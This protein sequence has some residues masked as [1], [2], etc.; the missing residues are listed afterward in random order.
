MNSMVFGQYVNVDSWVH[1]LDPRTKILSLFTLM[2]CLFLINNI[3]ILIGFFIFELIIVLSTRIPINKFLNSFK[4]VAMLLIFTFI[5]QIL[6]NTS[7]DILSINGLLLTHDFTLSIISLMIGIVLLILYLY[8][9]KIIKKFRIVLFVIILILI[10]YVQTINFNDYIIV[11]YTISIHENAF[12]SGIKVLLRVINLLTLS[13]LLTFCTKPTDLNSGI[14]GVLKPF[15]FMKSQISILAMMISIALRSIPTL[16]N[17]SKKIL[18]A[19]ASRGVDFEEGSLKDKINQIISLLVPMFVISYKKAEDLA[20]AMEARGYIPGEDRTKL[21]V[22]K[23]HISD[24]LVYLFV[25]LV[26]VGIIFGKIYK[27]L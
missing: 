4:A 14:E 16:L 23:Y 9:G 20:Y 25:C 19:Q 24:V 11:N 27:V 6:F 8:S 26:I 21:Q 2:I 10:F 3:Y 13:A 22:L 18:K 7:G 5:F 17:E 1:R 12:N 15:K